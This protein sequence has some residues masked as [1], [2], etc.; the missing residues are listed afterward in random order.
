M[1]R[2]ALALSLSV[3][4]IGEAGA[5]VAEQP[6]DVVSKAE[7]AFDKA[8][9][10]CFMNEA[11]EIRDPQYQPVTV[12]LY[13]SDE[14]GL[15]L[16]CRGVQAGFM[17]PQ[18]RITCKVGMQTRRFAK[19]RPRDQKVGTLTLDWAAL[20]LVSYTIA[21]KPKQPA[22]MITEGYPRL[23]PADED[24]CRSFGCRAT[25]PQSALREGRSGT[26]IVAVA[27]AASGTVEEC[28]PLISSGSADLDWITC[29]RMIDWAQF[30]PALDSDGRPMESVTIVA[31]PYTIAAN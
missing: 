2:F 27:V 11:K 13:G 17:T 15:P 5:S 24:A 21:G 23:R 14:V 20:N 25:F 8:Y 29:G 7:C 4:P 22:S 28:R 1:I 19:D 26:A 12:Y 16:E 9:F 18:E 30:R 6:T 31:V 10:F 3:A